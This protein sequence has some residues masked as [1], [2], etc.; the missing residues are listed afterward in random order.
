MSAGIVDQSE[1]LGGLFFKME[2]RFFCNLVFAEKI[3]AAV[4]QIVQFGDGGFGFGDSVD[5]LREIGGGEGLPIGFEQATSEI[6]DLD[7]FQNMKITLF[8]GKGF[9]FGEVKE[10]KL[11]CVGAFRFAGTSRDG[12]DQAELVRAPGDDET[13]LRKG[14]FSDDGADEL[15]F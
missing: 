10:I 9:D 11:S 14:G 3:E 12:F 5:Q 4:E 1:K 2:D 6:D 7:L 15:Q 8:R 13:G